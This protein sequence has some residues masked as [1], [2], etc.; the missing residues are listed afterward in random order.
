MTIIGTIIGI[1]AAIA[2]SIFLGPLGGIVLISVI[3]GLVLSTHI[4][5]KKIYDDLQRIKEKL[6]IEEQHDFNMSN[7]EIEEELENDMTDSV[8]MEEINKQIEKELEEY[9]EINDKERKK[10]VRTS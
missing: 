5:N 3:F 10:E 8:E 6:E 7:E 4:R 2:L 9:I 1:I